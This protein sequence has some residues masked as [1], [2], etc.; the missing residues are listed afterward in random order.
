MDEERARMDDLCSGRVSSTQLTSREKRRLMAATADEWRESPS[1]A[2]WGHG[3]KGGLV[4]QHG[5][6]VPGVCRS[7]RELASLIEE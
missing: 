3:G 1:Y 5:N 7:C 6:D 2:D 4:C